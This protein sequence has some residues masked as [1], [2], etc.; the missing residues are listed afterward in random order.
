MYTLPSDTTTA[1]ADELEVPF[2]KLEGVPF[3]QYVATLFVPLDT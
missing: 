2:A 3:F 1:L